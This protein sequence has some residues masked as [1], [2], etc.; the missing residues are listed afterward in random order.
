MTAHTAGAARAAERLVYLDHAATTAVDAR[1]LA[2]M[3]PYF[4][5]V[6]GNA[7]SLHAAGRRAV[8][9]VDGARDA[10]AA[11]LGAR[12][13][14]IYFTSG[15]TESDNWAL[16]G[17]AH[18]NAARGRHVVLSSV[19]HPAVQE[20]ARILAREGFEIS[21]A[22]VGADGVLDLAALEGLL[23]E[24]TVLVA[25][26][27]VNNETGAV[28][29]L[30]E[31]S[32]L[33]HA[34]GAL[35]FCDAVQ[36]A[37]AYVLHVNDPP[38]DLLSLSAHKFG[39]PK[40]VGALYVRAGVRIEPLLA[41]GHQER[42]LR[43]GTTNVPGVVGLA[44]ALSLARE[45]LPASRARIGGLCENFVCRVLAIPGARLNGPRPARY[46]GN[47][48]GASDFSAAPD[49]SAPPAGRLYSLANFSFDGADGARLLAL[50][51]RGGIA[52][53]GGAACSSG[54]PDP[55]PVLTAMGLPAPLAHGVRFSFGKENT[56]AD[57]DAAFACLASAVERLRG[58]KL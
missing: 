16:R 12:P 25:V 23:R 44:R 39:G 8:A 19:E 32:R 18:A 27:A 15:G 20:A 57:A 22:P 55:S 45:E 4:S 5:D 38:V 51:D 56:E 46:G 9:A 54:S 53:S 6:Y 3:L 41:G 48:A 47:G 2:A 50:L 14:E 34:R 1:V 28:Q 58:G 30:A 37:G 40:G 7:H 52:A 24:D 42:G 26:M 13:Q 31:I 35:F 11:L 33:C 36:A 29:P 43:G 21:L 17:A 49:A 10:V